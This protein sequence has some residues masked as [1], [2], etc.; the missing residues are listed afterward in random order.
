VFVGTGSCLAHI[1]FGFLSLYQEKLH[2]QVDKAAV[3]AS[4][5]MMLEEAFQPF[6]LAAKM[7]SVFNFYII[8]LG[9]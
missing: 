9:I 1:S 8:Q 4:C 7:G 6:L 3:F 2:H 5:H